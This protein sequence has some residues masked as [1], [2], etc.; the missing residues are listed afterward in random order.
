MAVDVEVYRFDFLNPQR[1]G[2]R[3]TIWHLVVNVRCLLPSDIFIADNSRMDGLQFNETDQRKVLAYIK[4]REMCEVNRKVVANAATKANYMKSYYDRNVCGPYQNK[5]DWCMLVVDVRKHKF[6]DIF[7]GPY[8]IVEKINNWNYIVNIDGTRKIVSISKLKIYKPNKYSNLAVNGQPKAGHRVNLPTVNL[9]TG[10]N[11]GKRGL[12]DSSSST[13]SDDEWSAIVTRSRAKKRAAKLNGKTK[14]STVDGKRRSDAGSR[15][16]RGGN[17]GFLA[18]Q[19]SISERQ[20][21]DM[22]SG[23]T[24]GH[25]SKLDLQDRIPNLDKSATEDVTDVD[26]SFV[27]ADEGG[28]D[29]VASRPSATDKGEKVD[30]TIPAIDDQSLNIADIERYETEQ[31]IRDVPTIKI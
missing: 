30:M 17:S 10:K 31:K 11:G 24:S 27:S 20:V 9:P 6:A 16:N 18:G 15:V 5:G 13:D 26:E 29:Q 1:Q 21:R 3:Q 14:T 19:D 25:G 4:Y 2:I 22:G 8:Q 12:H 28:D 23:G 7:K